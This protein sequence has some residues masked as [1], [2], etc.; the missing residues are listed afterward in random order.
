MLRRLSDPVELALVLLV[1]VLS[2]PIVQPLRAQQASRYAL[3]AALWDDHSVWLDDYPLGVD[4]AE[5][6]GHVV[7]DKSPGQPLLAVPFYA[8]YRLMGGEPATRLR[9]EGNLGLWWLSVSTAALP[10]AAAVVLVRRTLTRWDERH[11]TQAALAVGTATLMLPFATL[12]FSHVLSALFALWAWHVL[13]QDQLT[14]ARLAL[15]GALAGLAVLT[16]YTLAIAALVLLVVS[17]IRTRREAIWVVVGALPTALTLGAYQWAAFGSPLTVSYRRSTFS[18]N[19]AQLSADRADRS[20]LEVTLQVLFGER[21][22]LLATPVVVVG[23]VGLVWRWRREPSRRL[24]TG[25]ALVIAAGLILV[26]C[27]WSNATGGDSPGPRYATAAAVFVAPGIAFAWSRWR[28]VTMAATA[29]GAVV[30][31]SAAWTEPIVHPDDRGVIGR[32]L[33]MLLSGDWGLS[34]YELAVGRAGARILTVATV[35]IAAAALHRA[36]RS[37]NPL[38]RRSSTAVRDSA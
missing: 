3:T 22:L 31:L 17:V 35:G 20:T 16:E 23:L 9:V 5:H 6:N 38:L 21:G 27:L 32:W 34:V 28:T 29:I 37:E 15:G 11:A 25:S 26:Q 4:Q 33:K 7:S 12:L 10:A 13:T 19:A 30:M 8:V 24:A 18:Q 36:I 14:R 2:V 1:L